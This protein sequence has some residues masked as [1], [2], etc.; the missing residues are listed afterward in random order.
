MAFHFSKCAFPLT[1]PRVRRARA[2]ALARAALWG[3]CCLTW[4]VSGCASGPRGAD[5]SAGWY[6]RGDLPQFVADTAAPVRALLE[7]EY[8]IGVGDKL[9]VIFLYHS[10]LTTRELIVRRDG[11]VSLPYLGDQMAAG[12][13]PMVL[14]S[15]L[16]L[17][18]SEILRDPNISIIVAEPAPQKVFVL[19]EVKLPGAFTIEDEI[20]ILQSVA[21]AGGLNPGAVPRHAVLIRRQG[22]GKIVGI[23]VD[24]KS[25]MDGSGMANDTRLRNYDIV[26]IPKHPIYSAADFIKTATDIIN[27]PLDIVFKGWQI[28]NLSASYEFFRNSTG[29]P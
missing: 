5:R 9:D 21:M 23:E 14:D 24:L 25:I 6:K 18:F 10:N 28:A 2:Q 4:V 27:G 20:S 3:G 8:V 15:L 12:V 17:R 19:G 26:L 7:P 29:T 22:V 1:P 11:R 13:T 16:T